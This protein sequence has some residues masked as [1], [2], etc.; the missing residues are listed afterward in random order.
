MATMREP[1]SF[2]SINLES[3]QIDTEIDTPVSSAETSAQSGGPSADDNN[4]AEG[5]SFADGNGGPKQT[6][7][8]EAVESF[9]D[10]VAG[11]LAALRTRAEVD[12]IE[13]A[14]ELI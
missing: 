3:P 2:N 1:D 12:A 5:A 14:A 4:L 10:L 13:R 11:E 8:A 9:F 7:A 6:R